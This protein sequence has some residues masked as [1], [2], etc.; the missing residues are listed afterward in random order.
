M[1][2]MANTFVV[3]R[4]HLIYGVC[5]PLAVLIGYVLAEPQDSGS[6][7][8][9]TLVLCVLSVPLVMRWHHPLLIFSCN[10]WVAFFFLPGHPPLWMVLAF[11]SLGL[12]MVNRSLG[13]N[14]R[15]F[16]A[17]SLSYSLLFLAFVALAT[18][19]LTGGI[20]FGFLGGSNF[21]GKKYIF[22]FSAVMLYFALAT[23]SIPRERVNLVIGLFFL[24]SLVP[25]LFYLGALGGPF[26]FLAELFPMQTAVENI[27]AASA[28]GR[29]FASSEM[30]RM[31]ELAEVAKGLLCYLLA[32]NGA[33][34]L[35][36]IRRP[37]RMGIFVLAMAASLYSGFRSS[38]VLF[39]LTFA[40]MFYLE[41][42]FRT[43]YFAALIVGLGLT[44]AIMIPNVNRLP[45]SMQRAL[46][47]IPILNVDSLA[48][49]DASGSTNWRVQ[50]WK[51]LLPEIPRY[52]IKGRGYSINPD[53]IYLVHEAVARGNA[54]TY[55]AALVSGDYH[56]GPLSVIIPFG[57]G[58]VI[59]FLWFLGAG[60]YTLYC[61]F[62]FGDPALRHVNALLFAY[63]IVQIFI[64]FFIFGSL[65]SDLLMFSALA[66]L[67]VSLNSGVA[68]PKE[69]APETLVEEEA[70]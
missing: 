49:E 1:L 50:M 52:L 51:Q 35:M 26:S 21:G 28:S 59:A 12:T 22:F 9:I 7:A 18:A 48:R 32:R 15:F 30:N 33:K 57:L 13:Q 55:D 5:L 69:E 56:S 40:V 61:N 66:G 38:L 29:D 19:L 63:F 46:S 6:M 2:R 16:Q 68:R 25:L 14:L 58:G 20:G 44:A 34:G 10:A 31:T 53:E 41:G 70:E 8:V 17:R 4:A 37:W 24:S 23:H 45:L 54:S 47:F 42:L 3:S 67:S 62:R 60:L 27:E 36:D 64:F 43:R 39:P 11:I 65:Y